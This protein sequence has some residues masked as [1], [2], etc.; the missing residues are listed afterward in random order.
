[1]Y[2]GERAVYRMRLPILF[3]T[4]M[5]CSI[6]AF[7]QQ[8]STP[9][10]K[11]AETAANASDVIAGA[12]AAT[13]EQG[14]AGTTTAGA[15]AEAA[16]PVSTDKP[17]ARTPAQRNA[18]RNKNSTAAKQEVLPV[19][20]AVVPPS[21]D[22]APA[23]AAA[24]P[25]SAPNSG[26]IPETQRPAAAFSTAS[27]EPNGPEKASGWADLIK[28]AG[29]IGLV[30]SLILGGYFVFRRFAPQCIARRPAERTLRVI[31]SVSMGDKRALAIVQVGSKQ[32]LVA[33]T[34][35]QIALLTALPDAGSAPAGEAPRAEAAPGAKFRN[36]YEL[37]K[38]SDPVR[39]AA[40]P[41]LPPDIR[42]KMQQ[43]RKALEG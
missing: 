14:N 4:A 12:Q 18:T 6:S 41:V 35:G 32:F 38:K 5:L 24:A 36:L 31:E 22:A 23:V 29:G 7:A 17:A 37:E 21:Q 42:G 8:K 40:R 34:P 1:M 43:L 13:A 20:Q 33:S 2:A 3:L 9:K 10:P 15:Q 16:A 27:S 39:P 11:P 25:T 28:T 19:M 30:V 26:M